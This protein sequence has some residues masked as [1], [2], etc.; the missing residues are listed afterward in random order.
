M[1]DLQT[2]GLLLQDAESGN[3]TAL[4]VAVIRKPAPEDRYDLVLVPVR[5]E[6]LTSTLPVLT[7]MTDGSDVLFFGNIANRA[8][9]LVDA[10]GTRALFGFPAAGGTREGSVITYV[11]I[12]QQKTML[13]E[14]AGATTARVRHLQGVLNGA[15]FPTT[16]SANIEDWL[17]GHAAFVV[18]IAFALYR[19]DTDAARLAADPAT[20][21]LMVRAT[22]QAFTAL[23]SAGNAEIPTNL[24]ILYHLPTVLVTAYWRRVLAGPRGEL[25]F[26]AHSRAAP[27]E[28]R[29][30]AQELHDAI[31]RTRHATPDLDRLLA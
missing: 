15:G 3:R 1:A 14:P 7:A 20:I 29:A 28:M 4:P 13:G 23:S 30:L 11:L 25:W 17:Y 16:V 19:V 9:E 18:P 27:E 12:D 21:R 6:Q 2:H 24:R 10:L 5:A 31:R 22:R 8:T 26:A